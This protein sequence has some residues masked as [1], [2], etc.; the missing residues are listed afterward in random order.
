[1]KRLL[2][3]LAIVGCA[4]AGKENSIIGGI[5]DAGADRRGDAGDFPEPDASL[6]DAP[7]QQVTLTQNASTT[8]ARN[9]SFACIVDVGGVTFENSYYRVFT[10]S[11]DGVTGALHITQVSFGIE[12]ASAGT[13]TQQPATIHL[14]AYGATP[15]GTALDL[16]QIRPITSLD[17]KIPDGNGTTVAVPITADVPPE[18]NLIVE[19]QIP[20]GR[21]SNNIFFIGTNARGERKPGYTRAVDCGFTNPTTMQSIAASIPT[22]E[23]DIILTVTGTH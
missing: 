9:N 13:G 20:D 15:T 5:N 12:S 16:A 11:D 19:L 18:T 7:P 2:L 1:M 14:G 17:I 23:T 10:P 6:I 8:I 21:A 22:G 3:C 4:R